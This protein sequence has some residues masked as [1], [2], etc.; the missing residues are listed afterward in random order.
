M[1]VNVTLS[2]LQYKVLIENLIVDI[3]TYT[4]ID[5]WESNH[6]IKNNN[7]QSMNWDIRNN[8]VSIIFG[9]CS[10][11]NSIPYKQLKSYLLQRGLLCLKQPF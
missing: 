9:C 7:I 4:K 2:K 11:E 10:G 3:S 1:I 6:L 5:A 8:M